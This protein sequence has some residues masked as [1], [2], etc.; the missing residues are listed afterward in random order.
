MA[1]RYV[2][3]ELVAARKQARSLSSGRAGTAV[4][5]DRRLA[6]LR[7]GLR[8][9]SCQ[10][11][12]QRLRGERPTPGAP[13]WSPRQTLIAC[14][15]GAA[16][17]RSGRAAAVQGGEW[18]TSC[19]WLGGSAGASRGAGPSA[20]GEAHVAPDA[21]EGGRGC[22]YRSATSS[23]RLVPGRTRVSQGDWLLVVRDE[24]AA[25]TPWGNPRIPGRPAPYQR[26]S[27]NPHG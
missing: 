3:D 15:A 6:R 16:R 23:R 21:G 1:W 17:P 18:P 10:A 24:A 14:G 8:A 5:R 4:A 13:R 20:R 7:V 19:R 11:S 25:T 22:P 12:G 2:D 26:R 27:S 9:T